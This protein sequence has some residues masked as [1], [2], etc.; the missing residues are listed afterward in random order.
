MMK[1]SKYL[2]FTLLLSIEL[3]AQ[4]AG[5]L[6]RIPNFPSE[7]IEARR[8]D[9]WTPENSS[10]PYKVLFMHDG[11]ML[12]QR[13]STWNGQEWGV[14]E[15]LDSLYKNGHIEDIMVV[16]IWNIYE[17]RHRNYFPQKPFE[18][19]S[20][21]VQ[22]S[23]L[24]LA[25]PGQEKDLYSAAPNSDDYLQFIFKE[26]L[27]FLDENYSINK[28][29]LYMMG[30]SMGGLISMYAAME[31]S[32]KLKGV[33]CLSTHWPGVF[34]NENNPI[35]DAFIEY[36]SAHQREAKR[37][38]WYFDRGDA[39]LDALYPKPQNRVDSLYRSWNFE[40]AQFKSMVFPGDPHEET[41]WRKRFPKA[42]L[43]LLK[44][45]E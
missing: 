21:N 38:K 26:L 45:D 7:F 15:S 16:A 44:A 43:F 14:D 28:D 42:V 24:T 30:S 1:V 2:I 9:I 33:A 3:S 12:F 34:E 8:V 13:D 37:T 39:T 29:E 17:H 10:G 31:Y 32:R 22:D 41:A 35:P 19:L 11:Q 36:M 18:S 4:L 23:L 25:R 5:Q 40:S 20:Q 27:P 6:Q